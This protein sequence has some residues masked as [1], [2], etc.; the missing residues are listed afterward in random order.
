M[1]SKNLSFPSYLIAPIDLWTRAREPNKAGAS[2]AQSVPVPAGCFKSF[3]CPPDVIIS[4]YVHSVLVITV[5]H[6][7]VRIFPV[8]SQM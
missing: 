1:Q 4:I 2:S 3:S 7:R 8:T 5:G 6:S